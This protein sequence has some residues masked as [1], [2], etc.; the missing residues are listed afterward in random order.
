MKKLV[1]GFLTIALMLPSCGDSSSKTSSI[2]FEDFKEKLVELYRSSPTEMETCYCDG[3]GKVEKSVHREGTCENCNGTG[4]EMK[5]CG[6]CNGT[7]TGYD[8]K[9][10]QDCKGK[11]KRL[12][13]CHLCPGTGKIPETVKM[14]VTCKECKGTGERQ[15]KDDPTVKRFTDVLGEPD[16]VQ[17]LQG[18]VTYYYMCK[19]GMIQMDVSFDGPRND[20]NTHIAF[21]PNPNLY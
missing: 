16:K 5:K 2:S 8:S 20:P 3:T 9:F 11:G 19:D 6:F 21:D 4:K 17:E 12:G 14:I 7:G 1:A 15:F 10:C 13:V 18:T